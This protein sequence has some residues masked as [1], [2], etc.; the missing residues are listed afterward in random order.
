VAVLLLVRA[1]ADADR[2]QGPELTEV[3]PAPTVRRS[4]GPRRLCESCWRR[5]DLGICKFQTNGPAWIQWDDSSGRVENV[6]LICGAE[7]LAAGV[8]TR[9]R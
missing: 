6:V 5:E 3:K 9:H 4:R 1:C 7:R 8:V 2:R